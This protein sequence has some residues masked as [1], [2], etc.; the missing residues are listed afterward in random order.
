[1]DL[2]KDPLF[3]WILKF[4]YSKD[5]SPHMY[6]ML[7]KYKAIYS[8]NCITQ[9]PGLKYQSKSGRYWL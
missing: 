4:K 1:M 7:I 6:I 5:A 8:I 3:K 9:Q 2:V